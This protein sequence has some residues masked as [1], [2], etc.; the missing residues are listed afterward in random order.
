ME[1]KFSRRESQEI[2]GSSI[3]GMFEWFQRFWISATISRIKTS[4]T[5]FNNDQQ[6]K[7]VL[8]VNASAMTKLPPN[9]RGNL[10]ET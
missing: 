2:L 5:T 4:K 8:K 6:G 3:Q 9:C 10:M 1:V 7:K